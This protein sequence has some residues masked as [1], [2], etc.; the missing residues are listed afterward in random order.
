MIYF[1]LGLIVIVIC[2][3][4]YIYFSSV[5]SKEINKYI[6]INK[7]RAKVIK[8]KNDENFKQV[9]KSKD[10]VNGIQSG[11]EIMDEF[12]AYKPKPTG[13]KVRK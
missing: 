2:L 9:N 10:I 7:K 4:L 5:E 1:V 13:R 8:N 6:S 12:N 3:V 11:E